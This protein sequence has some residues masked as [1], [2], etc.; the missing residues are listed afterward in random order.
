MEELKRSEEPAH[1][2]HALAH[3]HAT[4]AK[5][6]VDGQDI[7]D[8]CYEAD[9]QE[10]HAMCFVRPRHICRHCWGGACSEERTGEVKIVWLRKPPK[11]AK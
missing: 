9:G 1:A 2:Q 6:Y 10:G 5:V 7:T 3:R 4:F 8:D 11:G